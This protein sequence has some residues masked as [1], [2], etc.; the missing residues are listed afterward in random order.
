MG[1]ADD[2]MRVRPREGLTLYLD[3]QAGVAGDMLVAALLDAG[4]DEAAMRRALDS[5]SVGGFEIEVSRVK[6]A[7]IDCC[8]F[9]V[10]LDAEHENRDHD[11]EYLHGDGALALEAD[12]RHALHEHEHRHGGHHHHGPHGHHHEHRGPADIDRIIDAADMSAGARAIA[13]RAVRILAEAEAKAHAVPLDQVHFHEVGAVDSIVD[14]VAASVLFDS[15]AVAR[16]VVPVLVDGHGTIR[17]QHGVIP[18]P[19]P[20]TLN[21][22]VACG[23]PL[24]QADVSG[25]LVT[26]T[27]AAL[28]AAFDPV[29]ELPP[30]YAVRAVGLGAGKRAYERPSVVRAWL[31]EELPAA[32]V[33]DTPAQVVKLE[34]DIDDSTPEVLAYAADRLRDAGARE[35]HWVPV[36]TKKGRPAYQLQVISAIEDAE[37][38]E[39]VI[40]RETSTIGVRRVR[41]ERT[42]L[43]RA[44]EEV[45]T[46]WGA[47]RMKRVELPDGSRREAPEFEDCAAIARREGIALQR[48]MDAAR[49]SREAGL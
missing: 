23:L 9:A 21:V 45:P 18:V 34:C 4:A 10:R 41:M 16:T 13:H 42:V 22:C 48:V 32:P 14:I 40:F 28:V 25:E 29:F 30:R 33:P 2:A 38:L 31:I 11:M 5:M 7:G 39:E 43:A 46:P 17:C 3:C 6:K 8:D 1:Q 26:P 27:G 37:R 47:V 35:V 36:F 24:A 44:I 19:A 12:P 49:A 15:L 20:A